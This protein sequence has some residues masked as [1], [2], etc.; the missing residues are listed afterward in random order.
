MLPFIGGKGKPPN[1][2]STRGQGN[3]SRPATSIQTTNGGGAYRF[4]TPQ[5]VPKALDL[6]DSDDDSF[7]ASE[8]ESEDDAPTFARFK[9]QPVQS[10][11]GPPSLQ[12]ATLSS[13]GPNNNVASSKS[14]ARPMS[15]GGV[16]ASRDSSRASGAV[17]PLTIDKSKPVIVKEQVID[18]ARKETVDIT[19]SESEAEQDDGDAAGRKYLQA[20]REARSGTDSSRPTTVR[21]KFGVKLKVGQEVDMA[22]YKDFDS[23]T[24]VCHNASIIVYTRT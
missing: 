24:K 18:M 1:S 21:T 14:L 2:A 4:A 17:T 16:P 7:G 3:L 5:P 9:S 22:L 12:R 19:D 11:H 8:S 6:T 10:S 15:R 23:F 20:Q 13:N